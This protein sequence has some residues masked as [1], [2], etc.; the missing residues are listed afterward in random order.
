M[1]Y[2]GNRFRINIESVHR[3]LLN[4]KKIYNDL[5]LVVFVVVAMSGVMVMATP[6]SLKSN[7]GDNVILTAN[8]GS[9][10][11]DL[12]YSDYMEGA[13]EGPETFAITDG[14]IYISDNVNKRINIYDEKGYI[15]DI[16]VS[17]TSYIRSI[18]VLDNR[19]YLMDYDAG[20]IYII[21]SEGEILSEISL[22]NEMTAYRM[23]KLCVRDDGNVYLKYDED[24][25]LVDESGL[26]DDEVDEEGLSFVVS[27][28]IVGKPDF[29][30]E[31]IICKYIDTTSVA[32]SPIDLDAYYF[33]PNNLIQISDEGELYQILCLEDSV[34]IIKKRFEYNILFVHVIKNAGSHV[35]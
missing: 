8:V 13:G 23:D 12:G 22:P 34:Q 16:D 28:D 6:L 1:K 3:G 7:E 25:Y 29:P 32:T 27:Y 17:Y 10:E 5:L 21:N 33:M 11:G 14:I 15:K 30:G 19:I 35:T 9:N 2:N 31:Y 4:A 18:V 24:Y 20:F 26:S